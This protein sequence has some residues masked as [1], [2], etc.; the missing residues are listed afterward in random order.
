MINDTP[1][2]VHHMDDLGSWENDPILHPQF[3]PGPKPK[4]GEW[5]CLFGHSHV[6]GLCH[7]ELREHR[8][9]E[10]AL[11][12]KPSKNHTKNGRRGRGWRVTMTDHHD[13]VP[14]ITVLENFHFLVLVIVVCLMCAAARRFDFRHPVLC[15]AFGNREG[16]IV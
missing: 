10:S 2:N 4:E 11:T 16:N 7:C 6:T 12:K 13:R 9:D 15:G 3:I 14:Y 1:T 8:Q 5:A